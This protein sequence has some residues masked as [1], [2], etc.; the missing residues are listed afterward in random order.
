[1]L[2]IK[3]CKGCFEIKRNENFEVVKT[4][5]EFVPQL[6]MGEVKYQL[7]SFFDVLCTD[8]IARIELK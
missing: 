2:D 4:G 6:V 1:M 5:E 3:Q 7:K 8:C